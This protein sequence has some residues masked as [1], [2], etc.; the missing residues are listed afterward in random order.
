MAFTLWEL[1]S[2]SN[3]IIFCRSRCHSFLQQKQVVP[4]E[5]NK[6]KKTVFFNYVFPT[7][8]W[9]ASFKFQHSLAK[10]AFN[11]HV[12]QDLNCWQSG[13]NSR[14]SSW[15]FDICLITTVLFGL[16]FQNGGKTTGNIWQLTYKVRHFCFH[17]IMFFKKL[18]LKK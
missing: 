1:F 11:F 8:K 14:V 16:F 4:S 15:W 12:G 9:L 13:N 3:F 6:E 18:L 17:Y 5:W 7:V 10:I 2:F